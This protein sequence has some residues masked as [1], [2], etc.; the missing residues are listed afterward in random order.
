MLT[1]FYEV[2]PEI[3]ISVFDFQVETGATRVAS[4]LI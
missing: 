2:V 3:L 4:L 1:G